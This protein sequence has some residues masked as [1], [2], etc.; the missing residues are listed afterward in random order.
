MLIGD[1]LF[2]KLNET[3]F[4]SLYPSEGQ[5][6]VASNISCCDGSQFME[7]LPYRQATGQAL[8]AKK[9]FPLQAPGFCVSLHFDLLRFCFCQHTKLNRRRSLFSAYQVILRA[10]YY[11]R[12]Y[13]LTL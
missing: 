12:N 2:E 7:K 1:S 9:F 10:P 6:V 8:F 3:D 4:A 11:L 13:L 5:R